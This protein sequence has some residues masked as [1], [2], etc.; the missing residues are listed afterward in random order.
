MEA[1][2]FIF[3]FLAGYFFRKWV[4]Q[5]NNGMK[6][7]QV[8]IDDHDIVWQVRHR[9]GTIL[10]VMNHPRDGGQTTVDVFP[11]HWCKTK[12]VQTHKRYFSSYDIALNF[13]RKTFV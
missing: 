6:L 12:R 10:A 4:G 7:E 2:I 3:G 8:K 9:D 1:L 11:H 13:L 5:I